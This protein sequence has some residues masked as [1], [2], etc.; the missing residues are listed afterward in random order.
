MKQSEERF[1]KEYDWENF[2]NESYDYKY[3]DYFSEFNE[4]DLIEAFQVFGLNNNSTKEQIKLKYRELVLKHHPD[5]NKSLDS[6][7]KMIEINKA[8]EMIMGSIV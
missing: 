4:E 5:K 8:Y 2:W 1:E 3:Y 7:T 6:T